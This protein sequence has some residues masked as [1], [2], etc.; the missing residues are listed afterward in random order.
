MA[1]ADQQKDIQTYNVGQKISQELMNNPGADVNAIIEN[2][3]S[4][5]GEDYAD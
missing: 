3:K 1:A 4:L 2:M 5:Y